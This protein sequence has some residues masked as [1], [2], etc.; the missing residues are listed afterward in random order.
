MTVYIGGVRTFRDVAPDKE[1]ALKP[2]EESAEVFGAWQLWDKW[3]RPDVEDEYPGIDLGGTMHVYKK[4]IV[5][6]CCDVITATCNLLESLG[7][8]DIR[9]AMERCAERNRKRGRL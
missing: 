4:I 8:T 9:E 2:L 3:N 7:V 6:E 1:Q 5:D